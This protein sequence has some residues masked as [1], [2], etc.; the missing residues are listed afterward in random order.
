MHQVL[1]ETLDLPAAAPSLAPQPDQTVIKPLVPEPPRTPRI[2]LSSGDVAGMPGFVPSSATAASTLS[3]NMNDADIPHIADILIGASFAVSSVQRAAAKERERQLFCESAYRKSVD[4]RARRLLA[5]QRLQFG[6]G[7]RPESNNMETDSELQSRSDSHTV[8]TLTPSRP[9]TAVAPASAPAEPV[10]APPPATAIEH[11]TDSTIPTSDSAVPIALVVSETQPE[12]KPDENSIQNTADS[13]SAIEP[14]SGPTPIKPSS[15]AV[16]PQGETETSDVNAKLTSEQ[17]SVQLA[18]AISET[19]SVSV[20]PVEP[21]A[22]LQLPPQ[23]PATSRPTTARRARNLSA[24]SVRSHN[25]EVAAV[26]S[27]MLLSKPQTP[28]PVKADPQFLDE[29]PIHQAAVLTEFRQ[30]TPV[31]SSSTATPQRSTPVSLPFT[32]VVGRDVHDARTP[33]ASETKTVLNEYTPTHIKSQ[34]Y[35]FFTS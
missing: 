27:S 12:T 25:S 7:V 6:P 8:A 35:E 19:A 32:P 33:S 30:V 15:R 4:A 14:S 10:L 22:L 1:I 5:Q 24:A 21:A 2:R 34:R 13:Q 20:D 3:G 11:A 9:G 28:V 31:P 18:A 17:H 16:T 29:S 23:S 26:T